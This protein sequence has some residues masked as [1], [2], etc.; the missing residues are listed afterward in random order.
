[1]V[2][3]AEALDE[4]VRVGL[5]NGYVFLTD[6]DARAPGSAHPLAVLWDNGADALAQLEQEIRVRALA[7]RR[8]GVAALRPGASLATLEDTLVPLYLHHRFQL[9]AALRQ[10]GGVDFR[11]ALKG[12]GQTA[13]TPVPVERQERAL[14]M[15]LGTLTDEFLRLDPRLLA[16]IPP[17][18]PGHPSTAERFPRNTGQ[19]LDP[20]AMATVSARLTIDGLLQRERAARLE[21][22]GDGRGLTFD[23]VLQALVD[24]VFGGTLASR[25]LTSI[26][27]AVQDVA[28]DR[29][30]ALAEDARAAAAVRAA[31][32]NMLQ[33]VRDIAAAGSADQELPAVDRQHLRALTRRLDAFL[34][35]RDRAPTRVPRHAAPPG[36]PIGERGTH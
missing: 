8:F 9:E 26:E 6:Q 23:G 4:L 33:R 2:D 25:A 19:L 16:R 27:R 35:R 36:S 10:I 31:A 22:R 14:R 13:S 29:A 11:H 5:Q 7:L 21:H 17:T 3:E 30:I 12:D 24:Q 18:P 15:V 20:V 28:V 1:G 34:Q 32:E